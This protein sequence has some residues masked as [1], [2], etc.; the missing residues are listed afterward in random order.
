MTSCTCHADHMTLYC[1]MYCSHADHMTLYCSM[2]CSH[3]DHMT[4]YC[5]MNCTH[6]DHMTLYCSM[7][8]SHADIMT[9]YCSMNCSPGVKL[10]YGKGSME[11]VVGVVQ[12]RTPI[13]CTEVVG[14]ITTSSPLSRLSSSS[15]SEQ[16]G[17]QGDSTVA[18][19]TLDGVSVVFI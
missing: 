1:S 8:C 13:V 19:C 10:T 14:N 6:A 9:L 16:P 18:I 4:L 12:R 3:A 15:S 7:N 2:Y 11:G 17:A 5:S